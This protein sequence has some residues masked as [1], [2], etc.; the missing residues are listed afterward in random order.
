MLALKLV[1]QLHDREKKFNAEWVWDV[2]MEI[3]ECPT[4]MDD[5]TDDDLDHVLDIP[6]T[7]EDRLWDGP[8]GAEAERHR[9]GHCL[10]LT[11]R[12]PRENASVVL[13]VYPEWG[14]RCGFDG[15]SHQAWSSSRD[16]STGLG[17]GKCWWDCLDAPIQD[18][19]LSISIWSAPLFMLTMSTAW[20][21]RSGG[22]KRSKTF[23][24]FLSQ[25]PCLSAKAFASAVVALEDA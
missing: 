20:S 24:S 19:R 18:A 21:P 5:S 10:A 1:I 22:S 4:T 2:L 15:S 25:D 14:R 13:T 3:L 9:S 11:S 17:T 12:R 8:D 7:D 16:L 6:T 23:R